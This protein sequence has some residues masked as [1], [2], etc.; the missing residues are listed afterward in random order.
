MVC[1]NGTAPLGLWL[2]RT[3]SARFYGIGIL[4]AG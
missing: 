1:I 4:L 3:G 2:L